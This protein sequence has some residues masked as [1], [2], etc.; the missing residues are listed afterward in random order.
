MTG[1][2]EGHGAQRGGSL[3][4]LLLSFRRIGY[5]DHDSH[6]GCMMA[7]KTGYVWGRTPTRQTKPTVPDSLKKEVQTKANDLVETV[8]KSK[9]IQ[10]PPKKPEF[11]FPIELWTKWYRGFFYFGSTWASPF[12]NQGDST[13]EVRFARLEYVGESRFNLAYFRHTEE[14]WTIFNGLTLDECLKSIEDGGPFTL[15]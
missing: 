14:W 7:K 3:M 12:P 9:Y 2:P 13:F 10:P 1:L 11:N 4:M 6:G 8:L 5:N 15:V